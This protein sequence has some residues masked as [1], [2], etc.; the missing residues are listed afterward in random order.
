MSVIIVEIY[1]CRIFCD[2][3]GKILR[4]Y[5]EIIPHL[6]EDR[7]YAVRKGMYDSM[8]GKGRD[9][10]FS[11]GNQLAQLTDTASTTVQIYRMKVFEIF[12]YSMFF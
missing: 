11:S 4:Y 2:L 3:P 7:F 5:A 9:Q 1:C 8:T 12:E 6:V 10:Y